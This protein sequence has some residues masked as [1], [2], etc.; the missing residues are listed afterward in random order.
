VLHEDELPG[1]LLGARLREYALT[2]SPVAQ[3]RPHLKPVA[4][5]LA[6]LSG[7]GPFLEGLN[8]KV[9]SEL[10]ANHPEAEEPDG[11][12]RSADYY[13]G[14]LEALDIV[15]DHLAGKFKPEH[16]TVEEN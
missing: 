5:L 11:E 13:F 4:E 10:N 6:D 7:A 9:L 1:N 16:V 8:D 15:L 14:M 3:E 12:E 2:L